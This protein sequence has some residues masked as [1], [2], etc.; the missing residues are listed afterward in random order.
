MIYSLLF[1]QNSFAAVASNSPSNEFKDFSISADQELSQIF[2]SENQNIEVDINHDMETLTEKILPQIAKDEGLDSFTLSNE[3]LASGYAPG[4]VESTIARCHDGIKWTFKIKNLEV[5]TPVESRSI[6]SRFADNEKIKTDIDVDR[7]SITATFQFKW[8]HKDTWWCNRFGT[9]Y[10]IQPTVEVSGLTGDLN[11]TISKSET[12]KLQIA[13][14]DKFQV[15]LGN[16]SFASD[17]L[18]TI[19]NLGLSV[20]TLFGSSCSSLT[21]CANDV[22]HDKL[23]SDTKLKNKLKNSINESLNAVLAQQGSFESDDIQLNYDVGFSTISTSDSDNLL[24]TKWSVDLSS[25]HETDSCA[26]NFSKPSYSFSQKENLEQDLN[27]SVPLSVISNAIYQV[28]R[29][30]VFCKSFQTDRDAGFYNVLSRA[31]LRPDGQFSLS[32]ERGDDGQDLLVITLPIAIETQNFI[33]TDF[34]VDSEETTTETV[35]V[36]GELKVLTE[37]DVTC[38]EGLALN[39]VGM[40]LQNLSGDFSRFDGEN[41]EDFMEDFGDDLIEDLMEDLETMTLVPKFIELK[42]IGSFYLT[43]SRSQV[44]DNA[45][46]AGFDIKSGSN[47]SCSSGSSTPGGGSGGCFTCVGDICTPCATPG[48]ID[49]IDPWDRDDDD[50]SYDEDIDDNRPDPAEVQSM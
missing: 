15:E 30:G 48:H 11:V 41:E 26:S 32:G 17:F 18:T 1:S 36:T 12:A 42:E 38:D 23:T 31:Q 39:V 44:S 7:F 3:T 40:E 37:L 46:N 28:G 24:T 21:D 43:T 8:D 49:I 6:Q 45:L 14:I 34:G 50:N 27:A 22:I 13:S 9:T 35:Q 4:W 19:A 47:P 2:S 10:N 5:K 33:S 16:V 29:Q 25:D 20:S